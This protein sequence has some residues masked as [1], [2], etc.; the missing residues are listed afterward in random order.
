MKRASL[1]Q[2]RNETS[3]LVKWVQ[4]DETVLVTK[5]SKPLFRLLPAFPADSGS[6]EVPDFEARQKA[7]FPEGALPQSGAEMIAEGRDRF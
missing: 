2:A 5:R 1:R 7:I 4:A 6:C 3:T